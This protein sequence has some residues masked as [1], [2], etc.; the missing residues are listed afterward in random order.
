MNATDN[1]E[2]GRVIL[3]RAIELDG[4]THYKSAIDLYTDASQFFMAGLHIDHSRKRRSDVTLKLRGY[5]ERAETLQ[6]HIYS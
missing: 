2:R 5:I 1:Y 3:L 4:K 6:V